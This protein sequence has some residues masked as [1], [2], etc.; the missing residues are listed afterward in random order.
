MRLGGPL[1]ED[2]GTPDLWVSAMKRAGYGAAYCP[3]GENASDDAINSYTE[4][5]AKA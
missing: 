1:F 3:V 2:C 5:A 4:A